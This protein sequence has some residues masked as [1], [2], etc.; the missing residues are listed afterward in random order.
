[1]IKKIDGR[2]LRRGI[3]RPEHSKL[4]SGSGNPKWSDKPNGGLDNLHAWLHRRIPKPKFCVI[5]KTRPPYD[6]ANI[7]GNYS[8]KLDDW[9]WICRKCHFKYDKK[10]ANFFNL[11]KTKSYKEL[12][13]EYRQKMREKYKNNES[14][15]KRVLI[16]LSLGKGKKRTKLLS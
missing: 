11:D 3:K 13:K 4:M 14:F 5:C 15:R 2:S 7:S 1:M 6:L 8:Y 12:V 9:M 10:I 16:N